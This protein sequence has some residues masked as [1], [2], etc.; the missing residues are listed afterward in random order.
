MIDHRRANA[1]V[2]FHAGANETAAV[3]RRA[4]AKRIPLRVVDVRE[5][6]CGR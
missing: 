4:R 2:V 3:L 6:V 1:A 5:L